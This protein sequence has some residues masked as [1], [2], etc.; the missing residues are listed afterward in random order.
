M[1]VVILGWGSLIW[2]PRELPR[3]GT[4][5][6]DG[7]TLPIE[8]SRVSK[9]ARLT[10]VIDEN[11]GAEVVTRFV[12]SPR[13]LI[14]D[15]IDD[16]AR[17][18]GTGKKGIGFIDLVAGRSSVETVRSHAATC[19]AVRIWAQNQNITGVVWTA[20]DPNFRPET[21]NDFTVENAIAYLQ[22][23]PASA[24]AVALHYINSAPAEV[25]TPVRTA[26]GVTRFNV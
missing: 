14:V 6:K 4:W 12:H 25:V 3:E 17:R 23:L 1:A 18:E 16:L 11:N 22:R 7:P 10:L 5:Q 2:D 20:L 13:T 24:C 9:D 8:F 21:G 19:A 15:A 26:V